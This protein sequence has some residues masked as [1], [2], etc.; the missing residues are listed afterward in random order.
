MRCAR[1][2][3][4]AFFTDSGCRLLLALFGDHRLR[5]TVTASEFLHSAGGIDKFLFTGEKGMASCANTYFDI[6]A[7]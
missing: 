2:S 3:A 7:S 6:P 1:F 5:L 4:Q